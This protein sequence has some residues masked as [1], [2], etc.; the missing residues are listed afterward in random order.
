MRRPTNP[1]GIETT[2]SKYTTTF[3][4]PVGSLSCITH[5]S[6][7]SSHWSNRT[8]RPYNRSML[9]IAV[10]LSVTFGDD[11]DVPAETV[12]AQP[13]RHPTRVNKPHT[14]FRRDSPDTRPENV[15]LAT[16]QDGGNHGNHQTSRAVSQNGL[17]ITNRRKT[18]IFQSPGSLSCIEHSC[19]HPLRVRPTSPAHPGCIRW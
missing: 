1:S 19:M 18:S 10:H 16:V 2:R 12:K 17:V 7:R 3:Q 6:G 5:P 13:A 11:I 4:S 8:F 9:N 15:V 14:P